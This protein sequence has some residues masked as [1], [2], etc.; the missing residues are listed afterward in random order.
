MISN[1][2]RSFVH[3]FPAP[4][5]TWYF[6]DVITGSDFSPEINVLGPIPPIPQIYAD[7]NPIRKYSDITMRNYRRV[8]I[9]NPDF[10]TADMEYT[11]TG[12]TLSGLQ[13]EVVNTVIVVGPNPTYSVNYYLYLTSIKIRVVSGGGAAPISIGTDIGY[14]QWIIHDGSPFNNYVSNSGSIEWTINGTLQKWNRSDSSVDGIGAGDGAIIYNPLAMPIQTNLTSQNITTAN[15]ILV[16]APYNALQFN[17]T[18]YP[19][20]TIYWYFASQVLL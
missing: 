16:S 9:N 19:G 12:W 14:S 2:S 20:G 13:T 18:N 7:P 11:I 1:F 10:A 6:N 3:S 4:N 15:P 8:V 17:V 5:A